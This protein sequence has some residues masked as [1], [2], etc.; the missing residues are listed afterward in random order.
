MIYWADPFFD[1]FPDRFYRAL[2]LGFSLARGMSIHFAIGWLFAA[3]GF[4]YAA[5]LLASG[6]WRTVVP[7]RRSFHDAV[8]V[9]LHDLHL[10][11][12]LPPA[13]RYNGAQ[14]IA[15]T[16]VSVMGAFSVLTG[17]AIYKPVQLSFL[18]RLLGGY[19]VARRIH[20]ALT[21]AYAAFFV[22]HV[23]QVAR[24]GWDNFRSMVTGFQATEERP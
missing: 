8:L 15:Y 4:V 9:V 10:S 22:I 5:Y 11:S 2:G 20:F 6:E 18:V 16:I 7:E 14:R 17:L 3:N 12:V 24:A 19:A 13:D 21:M 1:I 23:V